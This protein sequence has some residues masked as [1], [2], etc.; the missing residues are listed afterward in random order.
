[1]RFVLEG[2]VDTKD[3]LKRWEKKNKEKTRDNKKK[4]K[5]IC[6]NLKNV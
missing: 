3:R 4:E 6:N 1:M 2:C 5:I